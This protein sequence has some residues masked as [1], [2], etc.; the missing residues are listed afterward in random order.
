[1]ESVGGTA[2]ALVSAE[3]V[4]AA[5]RRPVT[6]AGRELVVTASIGLALDGPGVT[7]D[8]LLSYA[9]LATFAAKDL[10]GDRISEFADRMHATIG[11]IG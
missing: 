5:L 9:D 8:Q 4:L 11:P 6:V 3:R 10:G 2:D 7:T 1:M